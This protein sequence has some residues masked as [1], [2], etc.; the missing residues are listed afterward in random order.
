MSEPQ[1]ACVVISLGDEPGLVSAVRSLLGQDEPVEVVV[2]NTGGGDA[3]GTLRAGGLD[4]PLVH[5]EKRHYPGGARNLGLEATSAPFVSFLAADC[6]A[7]PGWAAGRLRRH[8]AGAAAVSS[9][10]VSA[11]PFSAAAQAAHMLMFHTRMPTAPAE[12]RKLYSVSYARELFERH[13]RFREDIRTGEDTDFNGRLDVPIEWAPEVQTAHRPPPRATSLADGV[14]VATP[15]GSTAYSFSAGGAILDPRLRNMIITPVAAYLSPLRSV[16]AGENHVVRLMLRSA[17]D[18]ALISLDGQADLPMA[19]GDCVE[20]RA[21]EAPLRLI[22]PGGS[23]PFYDLLRTKA[24]L[25]P[26]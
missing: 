10:M 2:V 23:T 1:L 17:R 18:G 24:G 16:V 15:T 4:V 6:V 21:L 26:Y 9:A 20:V 14:V 7:M 8:L 11:Y 19:E 5:R 12:G 3:S 13:G 22:E 25:L